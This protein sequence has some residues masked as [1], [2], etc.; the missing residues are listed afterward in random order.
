MSMF[1]EFSMRKKRKVI[2]EFIDE[3]PYREALLSYGSSGPAYVDFHPWWLEGDFW[4]PVWTCNFGDNFRTRFDWNVRLTTG[5]SLLDRNKASHSLRLFLAVQSHHSVT[6]GYREA[7]S[8]AYQK[9]S[10]AVKLIDYFLLNYPHEELLEY[11]FSAMNGG[12]L[13]TLLIR[14]GSASDTETSIYDWLGTLTRFIDYLIAERITSV[15]VEY[16]TKR[17]PLISVVGVPDQD[18]L[19]ESFSDEWVVKARI[20]LMHAGY[21][22]TPH[23]AGGTIQY[24]PD[25]MALA[26]VF[27]S[28]TLRGISLKTR[29]PELC[30][31]DADIYLRELPSVYVR[32]GWSNET[33]SDRHLR[34]LARRLSALSLLAPIG[35]APAPSA[36]EALQNENVY[37]QLSL[38]KAG[39]FRSV[40][41]HGLLLALNR[42]LTF[43]IEHSDHLLDSFV[44][45]SRSA[46]TENLTL[47]RFEEKNGLLSV[48]MPKT[49]EMGIQVSS[50][51]R[52]YVKS[53]LNGRLR[54]LF[55]DEY[56]SLLRSN[57]GLLEMV[58]VL[59]GSIALALGLLSARRRSE[60]CGLVANSCIDELG[61]S[62]VYDAAKTG[63]SG[64]RERLSRPIPPIIVRMIRRLCKFQQDL[65]D[66]EIISQHTY[67][68]ALPGYNGG[69][70]L[71]GGQAE[72][73]IDS[74]LDYIEMPSDDAGRRYYVRYHQCRRFLPQLFM[75]SGMEGGIETIQW[76]LNHTDPEQ[77][78]AYI[79]EVSPG[80][81]INQA[82]AQTAT[83]QLRA[84]NVA[85]DELAEYLYECFKV[86]DFWALT[87]EELSDYIL[88][89]EERK[90]IRIEMEF[91]D[92]PDGRRHRMLVKIIRSKQIG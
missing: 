72:T 92:M 62:L 31:G 16:F 18:R 73:A 91:I 40:P 29:I 49:I 45:L 30:F 25:N 80:D 22:K 41:T 37:K 60:L 42:S 11:G 59:Y 32:H 86:R 12:D 19:L 84:G 54:V 56:Y 75:D 20:A 4:S 26:Q 33:I 79:L 85:F 15:E 3:A 43:F 2:P 88:I 6:T 9:I 14:L 17:Y 13:S 58:R 10:Q 76:F 70:T 50:L 39:R 65:I 5:S 63:L 69:L 61:T 81:A 55:R 21:Y 71:N 34:T 47:K 77:V 1:G 67:L 28:G 7:P 78:W 87:D 53:E 27:Y 66:A 8:T 44:A 90:D 64:N 38:A 89:L 23:V 74:F 57:H 51:H 24:E 52:V 35:A 46:R 48:L 83:A 82:A 68:L 36:L